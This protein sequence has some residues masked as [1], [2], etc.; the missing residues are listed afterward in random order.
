MQNRPLDNAFHEYVDGVIDVYIDDL[1]DLLDD[2]GQPIV[3]SN[4]EKIEVLTAMLQPTF[5][6]TTPAAKK[7]IKINVI[8]DIL[9]IR[10]ICEHRAPQNRGGLNKD[11]KIFGSY[12]ARWVVKDKATGKTL[13]EISETQELTLEEQRTQEKVKQVS[14]IYPAFQLR[15]LLADIDKIPLTTGNP[16]LPKEPLVLSNGRVIDPRDIRAFSKNPKS[17]IAL[18]AYEDEGL[19]GLTA[20]ENEN[21]YPTKEQVVDYIHTKI[22]MRIAALFAEE[23]EK[24]ITAKPHPL[25][26]I[27]YSQATP[28]QKWNFMR[29]LAIE[30]S[31]PLEQQMILN[32]Q[33]QK[34]PDAV[35]QLILDM[36]AIHDGSEQEPSF[37][38]VLATAQRIQLFNNQLEKQNFSEFKHDY[39][40][41]AQYV[42]A[43]LQLSPRRRLE[44]LYKKPHYFNLDELHSYLKDKTT[45]GELQLLKQ[46][47]DIQSQKTKRY[48]EH[49]SEFKDEEAK[50][51]FA[52]GLMQKPLIERLLILTKYQNEKDLKE[53]Q[54]IIHESDQKEHYIMLGDDITRIN[55][56]DRLYDLNFIDIKDEGVKYQFI[57]SLMMK[58]INTRRYI[59]AVQLG[60][61]KHN[62][63][64]LIE[65]LGQIDNAAKKSFSTY[66]DLVMNINRAVSINLTI[67]YHKIVGGDYRQQYVLNLLATSLENQEKID[68]LF[69]DSPKNIY[70]LDQSLQCNTSDR[71]QLYSRF[72]SYQKISKL[73][74]LM[75]NAQELLQKPFGD[76]DEE[77]KSVFFKALLREKNPAERLLWLNRQWQLG[78]K[79]IRSLRNYLDQTG[80]LQGYPHY[81]D[82]RNEIRVVVQ[83]D[84]AAGGQGFESDKIF[85]N[86]GRRDLYDKTTWD[87]VIL[88]GPEYVHSIYKE[89][90]FII[91][92]ILGLLQLNTIRRREVLDKIPVAIK[93][94]YAEWI[95]RK[96]ESK[97]EIIKLMHRLGDVQTL[98][99]DLH[100][101]EKE[102]FIQDADDHRL[103]SQVQSPERAKEKEKERKLQKTHL[104][105]E[106]KFDEKYLNKIARYFLQLT[107]G[108]VIDH[109]QKL[110]AAAFII[111]YVNHSDNDVAIL[112]VLEKSIKS[113]YMQEVSES[114]FMLFR[115]NKLSSIHMGDKE[116][117]I[118]RL[119]NIGQVAKF[120]TYLEV[121]EKALVE[122]DVKE[123]NVSSVPNDEHDYSAHLYMLNGYTPK[124]GDFLKEIELGGQSPYKASICSITGSRKEQ[125]D[126]LSI[127]EMPYCSSLTGEE[128]KSSLISALHDIQ[129][130]H[131]QYKDTGSTACSTLAWRTQGKETK[132]DIL[133]LG[134]AQLADSHSILVIKDSSGTRVIPLTKA[135]HLLQN[136]N[137]RERIDLALQKQN[138]TKNP[139]ATRLGAE[140]LKKQ[141]PEAKEELGLQM[142]RC[143]GNNDYEQDGLSHDP[144]VDFITMSIPKDAEVYVTL[145]TDGAL[146][147]DYGVID[148]A[149]QQ[150]TICQ[151]LQSVFDAKDKNEL[152]DKALDVINQT[153]KRDN[154]SVAIVPIISGQKPVLV[155]GF[156]GNGGDEVAT[157]AATH[158]AGV[159]QQNLTNALFKPIVPVIPMEIKA[160]PKAATFPSKIPDLDRKQP[161]QP[162]KEPTLL[163]KIELD[164]SRLEPILPIVPVE[165]RPVSEL[166]ATPTLKIPEVKPSEKPEE[167]NA[168]A[169]FENSEPDNSRN[170]LNQSEYKTIINQYATKSFWACF[171]RDPYRSPEIIALRKLLNQTIITKENIEAA[172]KSNQRRLDLFHKKEK[173]K[174]TN[175]STDDVIVLLSKK[176]K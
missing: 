2:K 156:D 65:Y 116:F 61:H 35:N 127:N 73:I 152:H 113:S 17:N 155:A 123:V 20:R 115:K 83:T 146:E 106:E 70:E 12:P 158:F 42:F 169:L 5:D 98:I 96:Q 163:G 136:T 29:V 72:A 8:S 66:V 82:L 170:G 7:F 22:K 60:K 57:F 4:S 81:A 108:A 105:K 54:A 85:D 138:L 21:A 49:V 74:Q 9:A 43:L 171:F 164:N 1:D 23:K 111:D 33:V 37:K 128:V 109:H 143:L 93:E 56:V 110:M 161:E 46:V 13:R 79:H 120:K 94:K 3:L 25:D 50:I 101:K 26:G 62:I 117:V 100:P 14:Y 90:L 78:I 47:Q 36:Q 160:E 119:K 103:Y 39:L 153:V 130:Q 59:I 125:Q 168:P 92:S 118:E 134:T 112:K 132:T 176:F 63:P 84:N 140:R 86:G 154:S 68:R 58:D 147:Y 80:Y 114:L 129:T 45:P 131:G 48:H 135:N 95:K 102:L 67:P 151:K 11:A 88:A 173:V 28:E 38:N 34:N 75:K 91:Q 40:A 89:T 55:N 167:K 64:N 137:E 69:F 124:S 87:E 107:C 16:P 141:F 126:K 133:C 139:S 71:K 31:S 77:Q 24:S 10:K 148:F 104:Q 142:T 122:Q 30:V 159:V 165:I 18:Q 121:S 15:K 6:L 149:K 99:Y 175:T 76:L 53:L 174:K 97:D 144:D 44:L 172:L 32:R 150:S 145:V 19:L 51:Q 157:L 41:K 27:D 162:V 52:M 166:K